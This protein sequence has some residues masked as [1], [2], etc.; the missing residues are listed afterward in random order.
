MRPPRKW[1][2][3]PAATKAL[4]GEMTAW[5]RGCKAYHGRHV[6]SATPP[7][8]A[9]AF[10][11]QAKAA[12][13]TG[14]DDEARRRPKDVHLRA[15]ISPP[16]RSGEFTSPYGGVEPPRKWRGKPAATKEAL[17]REMT[18]WGC[19]CRAYH[20]RHVASATPPIRAP[21]F[22]GHAKAAPHTG[23][24]DE[25]RRWPKYVRLRASRFRLS[26]SPTIRKSVTVTTRQAET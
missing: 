3:K 20:G 16:K 15:S 7:I 10:D 21:A 26:E 14:P 22:D 25:P 13:Y 17:D 24:D 1:R 18:A 19:G 9:P 5:G 8:R 23:P 2:G 4:H 11:G 12:P 6:A